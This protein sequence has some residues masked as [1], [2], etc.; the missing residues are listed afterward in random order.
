MQKYAGH[1]A[2]SLLLLI[3]GLMPLYPKLIPLLIGLFCVSTLLSGNLKEKWLAKVYKSYTYFSLAFYAVLALGMLHTSD[4]DTGQFDL[5]V[6]LSFFLLP[7]IFMFYRKTNFKDLKNVIVVLSV[8][9]IIASF[10]CLGSSI[11][12][13]MTFRPW[14]DFF[15]GSRYSVLVHLGYFAIYLNTV[16][17][18][19]LWLLFWKKEALAKWLRIFLWIAI[20]YLIIVLVQTSSKMG[21]ITMFMLF[22]LMGIAWILKTKKYKIGI[23]LLVGNVLLIL[24]VRQFAPVTWLR[25]ETAIAQTFKSKIDKDASDSTTIRKIAWKTSGELI[26][27]NFW[28]GVG[29]GDVRFDMVRK[30]EEHGYTAAMR[31]NINAH[32]QY[33]QTFVSLGLIGISLLVIVMLYPLWVGVRT[34]NL[35]LIVLAVIILLGAATES[36]FEVQGGVVFFNIFV[37]FMLWNQRQ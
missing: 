29:T 3:I 35:P 7:I 8:S 13:Y 15:F 1:I 22:L 24:G 14:P 36:L 23:V 6:K 10:I 25:F 30:Y 5:E 19:G 28:V 18:G 37:P 27:E 11:Y 20:P 26:A 33:L 16:I 32:N 2:D 9:C 17:V 4:V 21:L 31:K 34:R 12:W